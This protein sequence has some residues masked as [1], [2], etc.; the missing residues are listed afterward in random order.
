M[1]TLHTS[2]PLKTRAPSDS[3]ER[4]TPQSLW[5]ETTTSGVMSGMASVVTTDV[6][7]PRDSPQARSLPAKNPFLDRSSLSY[8]IQHLNGSPDHLL[9]VAQDV[10]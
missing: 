3:S 8:S 7:I 9:Y 6:S 2:E 1:Q 4:E 5:R 10:V